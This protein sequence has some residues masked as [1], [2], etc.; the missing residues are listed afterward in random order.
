MM[1]ESEAKHI[2]PLSKSQLVETFSKAPHPCHILFRA[3][4]ELW[5]GEA[6]KI[7]NVSEPML[8]VGWIKTIQQMQEQDDPIVHVDAEIG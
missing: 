3:S 4:V 8:R 5:V 7:L 2:Y 1:A 6:D